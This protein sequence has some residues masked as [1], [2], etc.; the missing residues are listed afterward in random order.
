[1][2]QRYAGLTEAIHQPVH[3]EADPGTQRRSTGCRPIS[4][5]GK[6]KASCSIGIT[7]PCKILSD[8]INDV[9]IDPINE[10]FLGIDGSICAVEDGLAGI[11]EWWDGVKYD[12][13]VL[14]EDMDL[15]MDILD[16]D[17]FSYLMAW[18][19]AITGMSLEVVR[20]VAIVIIV[21]VALALLGGL[22]SLLRLFL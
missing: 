3:L 12:I 5:L 20:I 7:N 11:D 6:M 19:R 21:I 18:L 16:L 17:I 2:P 1:M 15:I 22:A 10:A 14:V 4:P 9:V 13:D 8:A